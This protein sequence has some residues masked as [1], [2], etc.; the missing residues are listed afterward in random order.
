[1]TPY[2][3][4]SE[5]NEA[6]REAA[7]EAE[8]RRRYLREQ[9]KPRQ[10]LPHEFEAVAK[11]VEALRAAG[12]SQVHIASK[13]NGAVSDRTVSAIQRGAKHACYRE[14]Y[15]ALMAVEYEAPV[16]DFGAQYEITGTQRRLAALR[17]NGWPIKSSALVEMSGM[18]SPALQVLSTGRRKYVFYGTYMRVK[19]MYEKLE[20]ADPADFGITPE[21]SLKAKTWAT[22][23]GMA[24]PHCWDADTIDDPDAFPEWTGECGTV[25]GYYLHLKYDIRVKHYANPVHTKPGKQQRRV[26]CEA[27]REARTAS[28][29]ERRTWVDEDL[30][31]VKLLKG[32]TYREVADEIGCSTRTIQR[33]SQQMKAEGGWVPPKTGPRKKETT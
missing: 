12:M 15:E 17:A 9:G 2:R 6:Q 11:K 27:C 13:T 20:M 33:I 21:A 32:G 5:M 29:T 25:T 26:L 7:R 3:L 24:P 1:M 22:K 23:A 8:R 30:V 16:G 28:I 31:R 14:T 10:I 18:L 19:E 4:R